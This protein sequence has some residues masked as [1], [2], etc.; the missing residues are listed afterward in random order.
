MKRIIL[1][2]TLLGLMTFHLSAQIKQE[3]IKE[4][5][6]LMNSEQLI[7]A[8]NDNIT[9]IF[10]ASGSR[11]SD[12]IKDSVFRAYVKEETIA[13]SKRMLEKDM[14]GIYDEYFTIAEIQKYIDFYKSPEGKK[15]IG[16]MPGIQ[17]DIMT[18]TMSRDMPE[19]QA[20]FK[21]KLEELQNN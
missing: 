5:L 16:A 20:K 11:L 4:L 18:N 21:K 12:P 1:L 3:K 8:M 2:T 17:K 10:K 9:T 19:L 7:S 14:V 6:Q 13:M 15:M